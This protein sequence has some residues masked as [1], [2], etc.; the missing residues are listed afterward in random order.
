MI[1]F[2]KWLVEIFLCQFYNLHI[3]TDRDN[4]LIYAY[5]FDELLIRGVYRE[6]L[7]K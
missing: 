1:N 6:T 2:T 3:W 4:I 7:S 5:L